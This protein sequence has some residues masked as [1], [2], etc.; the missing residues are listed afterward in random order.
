M[1][2]R[3]S[4]AQCCPSQLRARQRIGNQPTHR[5]GLCRTTMLAEWSEWRRTYTAPAAGEA[6]R[7]AGS[8]PR[9]G[10][11]RWR[12]VECSN[13]AVGWAARGSRHRQLQTGRIAKHQQSVHSAWP[14]AQ[15]LQSC[16][17]VSALMHASTATQQAAQPK[18]RTRVGVARGRRL[19][20]MARHLRQQGST[21]C[22]VG[23]VMWNHPAGAACTAAPALSLG[24]CN[25]CAPNANPAGPAHSSTPTHHA[26]VHHRL[27][28][29]RRQRRQPRQVRC[30][31]HR[32]PSRGRTPPRRAAR[33]LLLPGPYNVSGGG[34]LG[35]GRL[36]GCRCCR[37][38][39]LLPPLGRLI[40][41]H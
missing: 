4:G 2:D 11:S 34:C 23:E 19:R 27:P 36:L 8:V 17:A 15:Q 26:L 37:S 7:V 16:M 39:L 13:T 6:T 10:V 31:G 21:R 14:A 35:F 40:Q 3:C 12:Q 33:P 22:G 32:R 5:C 41:E 24:S 1:Q 18:P 29:A 30:V 25:A 9:A 28:H 20:H 38:L